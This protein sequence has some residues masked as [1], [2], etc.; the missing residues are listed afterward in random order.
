MDLRELYLQYAGQT[1]PSPYANPQ[2][3]TSL[4]AT[5][6]NVDY[7]NQMYIDSALYSGLYFNIGGAET[8]QEW[9]DRGPYYTFS[10]PKDGSS[11]STRVYVNYKLNQAP[12]A[13]VANLL[14]FSHYKQVVAVTI[15]NG[16]VSDV[17]SQ[18]A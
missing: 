1:R 18:L 8:K 17:Q 3:S 11:E 7:L 16:R 2:Y 5:T 13:G 4:T 9:I 6:L 15:A 12:G 10:W 14:L